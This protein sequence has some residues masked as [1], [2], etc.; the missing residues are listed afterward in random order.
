MAKRKPTF[1]GKNPDDDE[2]DLAA[3]TKVIR[4]YG[5]FAHG[6]ATA[7][8]VAREW[9]ASGFDADETDD[10]LG[11]RAFDPERAAILRDNG[12][13][14]DDA[15]E[16]TDEDFG[17]GGY[18]DTI[19]YKYSNGDVSLPKVLKFLGKPAKKNPSRTRAVAN[20]L[21]RGASR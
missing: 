14:A 18:G 8:D 17:I 10:W 11:S 12:V 20:R 4:Q 19:G 2:V 16:P 1:R 21:A 7:R 9:I 15:S 3:V 5:D 6:G 13:T